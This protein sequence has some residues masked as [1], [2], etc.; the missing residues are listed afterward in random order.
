MLILAMKNSCQN[1]WELLKYQAMG[2][3]L[4]EGHLSPRVMVV[5]DQEVNSTQTEKCH[6]HKAHKASTVKLGR[7]CHWMKKVQ[8][9]SRGL[10]LWVFKKMANKL[11]GLPLTA[12]TKRVQTHAKHCHT[13]ANVREGSSRPILSRRNW[14]QF[15]LICSIITTKASFA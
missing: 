7:F 11:V 15:L 1:L 4:P 6:T 10:N 2:H 13:Q 9:V 5:A 8:D 12:Q 14:G 3:N